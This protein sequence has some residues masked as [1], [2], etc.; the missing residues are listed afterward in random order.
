MALMRIYSASMKNSDWV[1]IKNLGDSKFVKS[2]YV[3]MF[4]IPSAAKII[5]VIESK[6]N[7]VFP[8]QQIDLSLPF[9]W[10]LLFYTAISF[11]I[12][13]I[14]YN[15]WCPKLIKFHDDFKDFT[16]TGRNLQ[17]AIDYFEG[18]YKN[19]YRSVCYDA[20]TKIFDGCDRGDNGVNKLIFNI[21]TSE[22]NMISRSIDEDKYCE[23][24]WRIYDFSNTKYPVAYWFSWLFF[25]TGIVLLFVLALQ[26][27]NFVLTNS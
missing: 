15:I 7:D 27:I 14:I 10:K 16:N 9:S 4:L 24:F 11:A 17:S 12:G 8:D 2:N 26:N 20:L 19:S 21:Y 25:K 23:V 22:K 3:W 18:M 6:I 13:S 1:N 5:A